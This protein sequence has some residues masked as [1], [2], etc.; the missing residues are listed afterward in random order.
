M[1]RTK[2]VLTEANGI[3]CVEILKS[4][5]CNHMGSFNEFYFCFIHL[6]LLLTSVH[7]VMKSGGLGISPLHTYVGLIIQPSQG[8]SYSFT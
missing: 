5:I 7:I 3:G 6:H 8:S 4:E 2:P 1:S